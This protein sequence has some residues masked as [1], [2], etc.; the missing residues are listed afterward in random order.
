MCCFDD[1][2]EML[3]WGVL[4]W[5]IECIFGSTVTEMNR[6]AQWPRFH[7]TVELFY[8][9]LEKSPCYLD[10]DYCSPSSYF[11]RRSVTGT[12]LPSH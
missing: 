7:L 6:L 9:S 3:S 4:Y 10:P 2:V 12:A 1:V 8:S 11:D 5:S